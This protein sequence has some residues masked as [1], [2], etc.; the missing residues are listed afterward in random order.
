MFPPSKEVTS[1]PDYKVLFL[2]L[3]LS[4]WSCKFCIPRSTKVALHPNPVNSW[5]V[6]SP[7]LGEK[8]QL[9]ILQLDFR[10]TSKSSLSQGYHTAAQQFYPSFAGHVET[11]VWCCCSGSGTLGTALLPST[12][13]CWLLGPQRDWMSYLLTPSSPLL[14]QAMRAF[15]PAAP[16]QLLI[17]FVRGYFKK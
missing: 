6:K 3:V 11:L 1:P 5:V 16:S 10:I 4:L 12:P 7:L 8:P 13:V 15:I 14:P 9:E 17:Y 2:L